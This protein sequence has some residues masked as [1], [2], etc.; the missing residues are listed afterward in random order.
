MKRTKI[1]CTIGPASENKETL[2]KMVRSGMDVARLN[3]SHG[4]YESHAALI[5]NI[6]AMEEKLN[7]SISIIA[8]L[9]GP[10]IRTGKLPEEG[11]VLKKGERAILSCDPRAKYDKSVKRIP[12]D[13]KGLAAD[14]SVGDVILLKDGL[15][16]LQIE[17]IKGSDLVCKVRLGGVLTTGR[18]INV[19]TASLSIDA[20]TAKD[21]RDVKFAVSQGVDYFALSFVTKAKEIYD[22]RYLIKKYEKELNIK[23]NRSIKIIA[24][25]EKHEAVRHLDEI[26]EAVDGIM[27][28]RG[29]L[30][31]EIPAE[32]VPLVQK[33]LIEKC[34]ETGKPVI[35]ATQMLDSMITNPR[36]TRAEV[37]DVANAVIDHTDAVMLSGES[38]SGKYPVESVSV[39]NRIIERTEESK[40]D[41]LLVSP[42]MKNLT[43]E[44]ALGSLANILSKNIKTKLILVASLSGRTARMVSRFRPEIPIMVAAVDKRVYRQMSLIWGVCPFMI[45]LCQSLEELLD[46]SIGHL[47]TKKLLKKG[48]RIIIVGGE[49]VGAPGNINLLEIKT[50]T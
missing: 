46:R 38:A 30:G 42:V 6:R 4:T 27:V 13:Y 5:K 15:L 41:D 43:V 45:P 48:D 26:L 31:I 21:K 50:I 18:G 33:K 22:L 25:I 11:V 44:G 32:H 28:A 37:S 49:P 35:V 8:D 47:K 17:K 16:D 7:R 24:K 23:E 14:L 9:Q 1:V 36:P 10:R 34:M 19:P 40:Y 3:F 12:V 39:M 2:Q 29:D 20:I